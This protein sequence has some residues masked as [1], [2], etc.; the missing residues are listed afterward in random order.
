MIIS[1][2]TLNGVSVYDA[3][4]NS[5]GA[6]LYVDAGQAASY[7][8]SGSTWTDLSSTANNVTLNGSPTYSSSYGGTIAFNGTT[9]Q[10]GNTTASKFNTTYTGKTTFFAVRMN[11]S[12]WTSGVSQYRC[13]FGTNTGTRNFNTY[14]YHDTSNLFYIHYSANGLGGLSNSIPITTNQWFVVAVTH[15]TDGTLTYYLNGQPVN[16]QTGVT[17]SHYASNGGEFVGAGDN[18]WYGDIALC[19]IYGRTLNPSEVRKNYNS[20]S[21]RYGI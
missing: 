4:F 21:N 15:A 10:W 3:T 14:I 6:L 12:A 19:A 2:V 1:G 16:V 9:A 7:S 20:I 13:L 18:Y 8:G 17:F 5:N 11:A